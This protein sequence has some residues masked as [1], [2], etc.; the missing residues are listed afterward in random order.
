MHV[1]D[2]DAHNSAID[3]A[4][5]THSSAFCSGAQETVREVAELRTAAQAEMVLD[6]RS[7]RSEVTAYLA[8]LLQRV[9]RQ[10]VQQQRITQHQAF[11]SLPQM[12]NEDLPLAQDEVSH[13]ANPLPFAKPPIP[14]SIR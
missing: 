9:Q 12:V 4:P 1:Q 13:L 3:C 7:E 5:V 6:A 2:R 14:S 11:L 8:D 10:Q